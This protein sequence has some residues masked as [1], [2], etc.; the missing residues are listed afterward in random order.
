MNI[1]VRPI[2]IVLLI[3]VFAIGV[4]IS[5]YFVLQVKAQTDAISELNERLKQAGLHIQDISIESRNPFQI[6][7]V[8]IQK[9]NDGEWSS[10]AFW[11]DHLIK[12]EVELSY[13]YGHELDSYSLFYADE[14]GQ[15]MK[16]GQ[17][18]LY[19]SDPSQKPYPFNSSTPDDQVVK[20]MISERIELFGVNLESIDVTT[21][22]GSFNDVQLLK[23]NLSTNDLQ[24][25]DRAA[26]RIVLSIRQ[27]VEEINDE[28]GVRIA[29]VWVE[30]VDETQEPLLVYLWDLELHNEKGGT[31]EGITDGFPS[32]AEPEENKDP[33]RTPYPTLTTQPYPEPSEQ[34]TMPTTQQAYP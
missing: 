9:N 34:K 14:N 20:K 15:I 3:A 10:D 19:P 2:L 13:K 30:L 11:Q 1:K 31:A 17:K 8:V 12:R 5:S 33:T 6:E 29:V 27:L 18:F 4:V 22:I 28:P 16:G 26:S 7:I 24:I 23:I 21:G 32:P 25:A